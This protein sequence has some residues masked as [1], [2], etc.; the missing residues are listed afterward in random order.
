M[1]LIPKVGK[2]LIDGTN[3]VDLSPCA[4]RGRLG[5]SDLFATSV[6]RRSSRIRAVHSTST[7]R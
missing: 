7:G 3:G 2:G 1:I 4:R 6:A 5:L